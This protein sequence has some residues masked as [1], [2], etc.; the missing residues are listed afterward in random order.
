MPQSME[1]DFVGWNKAAESQMK[2]LFDPTKPTPDIF[3]NT[4]PQALELAMLKS[5]DAM[6]KS[7]AAVKRDC[8][9]LQNDITRWVVSHV[10]EDPVEAKWAGLSEG[11]RRTMILKGLK[12]VCTA[13]TDMPPQ[14]SFVPEIMLNDL[15]KGRAFLDLL[16]RVCF[17]E[18][19]PKDQEGGQY[20]PVPN[21]LFSKMVEKTT[22]NSRDLRANLIDDS[23]DSRNRFI[24][25]FVWSVLCALYGRNE[26]LVP[27][28]TTDS[29]KTPEEMEQMRQLLTEHSDMDGKQA[30]KT[31][32][33]WA[34]ESAGA[35]R[36][37]AKCNK[38]G[39]NLQKCSRCLSAIAVY[40]CD[41]ACQVGDWKSHK[42]ACGQ[43]VPSN[44]PRTF[45]DSTP[46]PKISFKSGDEVGFPAPAP[47]FR[48][49]PAL[50]AQIEALKETPDLDYVLFL[51]NP[52]PANAGC[53][54]Q[55]P[56][57]SV[58]FNVNRNRA[59]TNGDPQAVAMMYTQLEAS[60]M[61]DAQGFVLGKAGLKKQLLKE[62]G[63]DVDKVPKPTA[64]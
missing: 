39:K 63:V 3:D 40:Y 11:M 2:Q 29:T 17:D 58:Y 44:T 4:L 26:V 33:T 51:P 45:T 47:G 60:A 64:S 32:K 15:I 59:M 34:D 35:M 18:V 13:T 22:A 28:A 5:L 23:I 30:D 12:D 19:L 48:R 16:D 20:I 21:V 43:P 62:Y 41:R 31:L 61:Q 42:K 7:S 10:A 52:A 9:L 56:L 53:K 57:G 54:I 14:R 25:L 38:L 27:S 46:V 8:F 55:H 36:Q 6:R 37:C 50:L 49:S 1:T 24:F